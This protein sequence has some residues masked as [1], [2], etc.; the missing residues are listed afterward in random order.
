[1][2]VISLRY[3]PK[4]IRG[5]M[6]K[7]NSSDVRRWMLFCFC[8]LIVQLPNP[9]QPPSLFQVVQTL[10]PFFE[11]MAIEFPLQIEPEKA[12]KPLSVTMGEGAVMG[13]GGSG[14]KG[15]KEVQ[16]HNKEEKAVD[17]EGRGRKR[18]HGEKHTGAFDWQKFA[19]WTKATKAHQ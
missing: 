6:K 5:Q 19:G 17:S 4:W 16:S 7:C 12:E 14:R 9:L 2:R 1:M 10:I 15:G 18:V 3:L 8:F 11:R 13:A